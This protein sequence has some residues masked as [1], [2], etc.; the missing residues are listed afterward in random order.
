LEDKGG[1]ALVDRYRDKLDSGE[2]TTE[3]A[4]VGKTPAESRL[5]VDWGA[6][7]AGKLTDG[8]DTT[9]DAAK[10]TQLGRTITTIPDDVQLHARVAKVYE[11]RRRMAA[12]EIPA[13]WGFAENLAYATL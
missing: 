4:E 6:L 5:F 10:L 1:Q 3:L 7:V 2:V 8:A 13:D 12:G 11:D 9:V